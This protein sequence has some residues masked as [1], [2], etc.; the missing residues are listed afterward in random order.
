MVTKN[1]QPLYFPALSGLRVFA[2]LL[3]FLSHFPFIKTGIWY[4]ALLELHIGVVIFFVLSG[5][6]I[7]YRHLPRY[8][9]TF[10][11]IKHFYLHRVIRI[12]PIYWLV[13]L[14]VSLTLKLPAWLWWDNILLLK[15]FTQSIKFSGIAPAWALTVELSFYLL[16]PF[17]LHAFKKATPSIIL[18]FMVM[19]LLFT[20]ALANTI[21]VPIFLG[22]WQFILVYTIFGRFFEFFAG[23]YLAYYLLQEKPARPKR[24]SRITVSGSLLTLFFLTTLIWLGTKNHG[25]LGLL[26]PLGFL[27]NNLGLGLSVTLLV[28]GLIKEINGVSKLLSTKVFQFLSGPSYIFFLLHFTNMS[29]GLKTWLGG[30]YI[31]WFISLWGVSAAGYYWIEKPLTIFLDKKL[32]KQP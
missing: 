28:Y 11:W 12:F 25:N 16:A 30:N 32:V 29:Y 4:H 15:G 3:I 27:V 20:G 26:H 31:I 22:T 6:L 10:S 2:T 5:F 8:K 19:L 23:S 17:W 9:S 18:L 7:T 24:A 14:G 1:T 13:L 21:R